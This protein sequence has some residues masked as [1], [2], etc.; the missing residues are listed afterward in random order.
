MDIIKSTRELGKLLQQDERYINYHSAR[1]KNDND[2]TLQRLIGDFNLK[3]LDLNTEMS[4]VD[5]NSERLTALDN[6]IKE[7]HAQIMSNENMVAFNNAKNAMDEMLSQINNIITM[8]ANG[9]DPETCPANPANCSG[10]CS[11]CSGCH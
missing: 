6:E 5:R 11:S 4:K 1:E 2:E 9:E 7:L 3:R 10:G 8:S